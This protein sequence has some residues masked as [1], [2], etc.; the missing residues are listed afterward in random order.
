MSNTRFYWYAHVKRTIEN[1]PDGI[2]RETKQGASDY[3]AV[4]N[5]INATKTMQDGEDRIK[6]IKMLYWSNSHT[7]D[8]AAE[9]LHISARTAH[10]WRHAFVYGVARE[11]GYYN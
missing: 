3:I 11:M 6:L 4:T 10:R 2:D 8:G 9:V 5:V 7:I 1:Y